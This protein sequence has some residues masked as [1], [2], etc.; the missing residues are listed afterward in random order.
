MARVGAPGP[1]QHRAAGPTA[2][3]YKTEGGAYVY[4][5]VDSDTDAP[6][7]TTLPLEG[8]VD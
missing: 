5:R 4:L 1:G 6:F 2:R 7:T 3:G 8:S